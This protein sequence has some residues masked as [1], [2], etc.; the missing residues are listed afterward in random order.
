MELT[1]YLIFVFMLKS[2]EQVQNFLFLKNPLPMWIYEEEKMR[3][4]AAN[5]AATKVF[6]YSE[7]EFILNPMFNV[8]L[9]NEY[10]HFLG[11]LKQLSSET[12][13]VQEWSFRTKAGD[14]IWVV[15]HTYSLDESNPN[16][17]VMLASDIRPQKL[18][19]D[20]LQACYADFDSLFE[21]SIQIKYLFDTNY[22]ILKANRKA[23]ES[24]VLVFEQE[25]SLKQSILKYIRGEENRSGFIADFEEARKGK[26]IHYE[27]NF[28]TT[29]NQTLWYEINY[30]PILNHQLEVD[31][32]LLSMHDI[33]EKKQ[34]E[35]KVAQQI[36]DLQEFAFLT[37]HELRR[38]LANIL[39]LTS[40]FNH[41]NLADEFNAKI[42][43]HLEFTALQLDEIIHKM[44]DLLAEKDLLSEQTF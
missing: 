23:Y 41:N 11:Y 34:I 26:K 32:I 16:L 31:K 30:L 36:Q 40:I 12:N 19:Q 2:L 4:L 24:A 29:R 37:S 3:F 22:T 6:G 10:A 43:Q 1:N 7:A 39:G 27:L 9:P 5:H 28:K 35:L 14:P 42:I 17:K 21:S 15:I 20:K 8:C 18:I 25:I 13:Q 33:T 44:N 38:P